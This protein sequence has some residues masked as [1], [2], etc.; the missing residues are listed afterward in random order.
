MLDTL[1]LGNHNWILPA[2]IVSKP[3]SYFPSV[4]ELLLILCRR[5]TCF[6]DSL[7]KRLSSP[8]FQVRFLFVS[9]TLDSSCRRVSGNKNVR[10]CFLDMLGLGGG[11]FWSGGLMCVLA[12]LP[13]WYSSMELIPFPLSFCCCLL[14]IWREVKKRLPLVRLGA[15]EGLAGICLLQ[16]TSFLVCPWRN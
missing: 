3:F 1:F 14:A 5:V 15:R 13:V 16:A 2:P 8:I 7:F 6:T 9:G 10:G 12:L 4:Q 11:F